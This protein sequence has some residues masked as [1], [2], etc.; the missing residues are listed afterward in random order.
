MSRFTSTLYIFIPRLQAENPSGVILIPRMA[1]LSPSW[2]LKLH[3]KGFLS[4]IRGIKMYKVKFT[5]VFK[6]ICSL[7]LLSGCGYHTQAPLADAGP[8]SITVPYIRG[9]VEG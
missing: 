7:F 8:I 5:P 4:W 3:L 2:E 1:L 9:D 6:L